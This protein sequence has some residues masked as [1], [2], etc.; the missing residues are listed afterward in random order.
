MTAMDQITDETIALIRKA[1]TAG[2]TYQSGLYGYDLSGVVSWVPVVTP[3]RDR[4]GRR[5]AP[6]GSDAARWRTQLNINGSQPNPFTGPSGVGGVVNFGFHFMMSQYYPIRQQGHIEYDAI[7]ASRGYDDEKAR[8]VTGSLMQWRIAENKALISGQNWPLPALTL[9]ALTTATTGGQIA[10][11]TAVYVKVQARS[12]YNY[13]FGGSG[14]AVAANITTGAGA[15]N[16]VTIPSWPNPANA[17]VAYDIFAGPA[18]GTLYY[19]TTVTTNAAYTLTAIP[20]ANAVVPALPSISS[21]VP[22]PA[23]SDSSSS[24]NAFNGLYASILGDWS[25]SGAQVAPGAGD[26]G[27]GSYVKSLGGAT[28]TGNGQGI[29]ELDT[30]FLNY[31]QNTG[32]ESPD[33]LLMNGQEAQ[34]IKNK[35]LSTNAAVTYL[36]PQGDGRV[37]TTVGGSVGRYINGAAGGRSV[38]IVVD[39]H[40]PPGRILILKET[41][42]YPE[43]GESANFEVRTLREVA[44]RPYGNPPSNTPGEWWDIS[45]YETFLNR[46]PVLCGILTDIANG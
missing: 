24:A 3:T 30:A 40:L 36:E 10:A 38:D 16:S 41:N 18:A 1:Q 17:A 11:T 46:A 2:L 19:V 15:T 14:I 33:I 13:H 39:P 32:G 21:T 34:N 45:S 27:A 42:P 43:A 23:T 37:G 12:S 7:D 5:Q 26:L 4:I 6:V 25:S 31:F 9:P 8:A 44:E 29:S 22:T 35:T 20:T 28:L